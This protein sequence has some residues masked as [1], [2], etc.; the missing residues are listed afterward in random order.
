MRF[1]L[2]ILALAALAA[3]AAANEE[4]VI[5]RVDFADLDLSQDQARVA[6]EERIEAQLRDACTVDIRSRYAYGRTIVDE[7]C[8]AEARQAAFAEVERAVM[9]RARSGRE[10]AAN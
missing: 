5:V 1:A 8:V 7:Q 4:T 3:P 6:L 9:A 10:V 2:P